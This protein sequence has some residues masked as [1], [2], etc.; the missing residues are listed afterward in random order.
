M[1][2]P[3]FFA[4]H[5]VYRRLFAISNSRLPALNLGVRL[6]QFVQGRIFVVLGGYLRT[7]EVQIVIHHLQRSVT[8]YF[9]EGKYVAAIQQVI[10]GKCM[11]AQVRMQSLYTRA[12]C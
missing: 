11:P 3:L 10:Y 5:Y 1:N 2:L 4:S 7:G 12:F 8:K 6:L 9:S